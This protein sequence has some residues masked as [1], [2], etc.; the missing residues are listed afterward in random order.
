LYT[1]VFTFIWV[2][3]KDDKIKAKFSKTE[4]WLFAQTKKIFLDMKKDI[5]E[6]EI[7]KEKIKK[8][9]K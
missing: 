9:K 6:Y 1:T 4:L 2:L 7:E 3:L 8:D 5:W